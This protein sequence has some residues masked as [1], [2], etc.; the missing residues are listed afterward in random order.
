MAQAPWDD[1]Q[2]ICAGVSS[3][4]LIALTGRMYCLGMRLGDS[5][6]GHINALKKCFQQ[7]EQ[8]KKAT[9][10]T[11]KVYKVYILHSSLSEDYN[12]LITAFESVDTAQLSLLYVCGHLLEEECW[13]NQARAMRCGQLEGFCKGQ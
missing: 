13:Q 3:G 10:E 5:M 1:L 8:R 9:E 7:L 6:Q 12:T 11:D 4:S 2:A